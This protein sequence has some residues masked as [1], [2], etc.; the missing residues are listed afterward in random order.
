MT[1]Q[2][3]ATS[4][5]PAALFA[6]IKRAGLATERRCQ[7]FVEL[8]RHLIAP[9]TIGNPSGSW[10]VIAEWLCDAPV[11]PE[12]DFR[13]DLLRDV[14]PNPFR[15]YIVGHVGSPGEA[16][17]IKP[18]YNNVEINPAWLTYANGN[19]PKLAKAAV[20]REKTCPRCDGSKVERKT[21]RDH[22]RAD[23][24]FKT[25]QTWITCQGPSFTV[26]GKQLTGA[27]CGGTGTITAP[28]TGVIDPFRLAVLADALEEA[29]CC[30]DGILGHLRA[31]GP[32]CR[33]CEGTRL[34]P[35]RLDIWDGK[36]TRG[37]HPVGQCP[38]CNGI[39][40]RPVQH[41]WTEAG[42]CWVVDLLLGN[43]H[44]RTK[45]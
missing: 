20:T 36:L 44:E 18:G 34:V 32:E 27:G 10:N 3:Y 24:G 22:E 43:S 25:K 2:Q 1:E 7:A 37:G 28:L 21:I 26:E 13:C 45:S 11:P 6:A 19:V 42:G 16:A 5:D 23:E 41:R 14:F 35:Y 9:V 29:G 8:C 17:A 39:G 33:R 40:V 15:E 30:D 4:T 12:L 38:D 31:T